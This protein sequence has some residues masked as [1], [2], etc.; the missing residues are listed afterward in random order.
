MNDA[1]SPAS[2]VDGNAVA[3]ML[4]EVLR[5]DATALATTCGSCGS[6]ARLAEAVVELC[7][8]SAVVRCRSCTHTLVTL[9]PSPDGVVL[10]AGSLDLTLPTPRS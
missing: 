6:R 1:H 8:D 2:I 9:V 7:A 3:G 10:R 4:A 5:G